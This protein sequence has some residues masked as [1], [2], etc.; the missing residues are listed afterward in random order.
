VVRRLAILAMP[1]PLRLRHQI[2]ADPR[3]QG[4]A[5]RYLFGFQLPWRP[6]RV[7]VAENAAHV[8]TLLREW[9]GA[10]Y[11][12]AETEGRYRAAMRIPGVA[13][14][15][16][17]YHRWVF[18]SLF[19]PDGARFASV[20]RRSLHVDT[21]QIHGAADRCFLAGT[22]QG[23]GRYVNGPYTWRL[24]DG[25]GHFPHEEIP[26]VVNAELLGWLGT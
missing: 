2:A 3:G 9:G 24:H 6:E 20:L 26:D 11:P 1:H 4:V 12:D 7:L 21:L 22:A 8:A 23:S 15:S 13:H 5:S 16:L 17:E 10:G 19:R 25:V 18:R 14:S